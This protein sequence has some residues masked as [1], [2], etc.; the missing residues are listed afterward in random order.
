MFG[1]DLFNNFCA[2]VDTFLYE[3]RNVRHQCLSGSHTGDE[4]AAFDEHFLFVIFNFDLQGF[5]V[6]N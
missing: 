5:L 2:I 6:G 4:R 3:L 1:G